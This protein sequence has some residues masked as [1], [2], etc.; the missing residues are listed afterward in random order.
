MNARYFTLPLQCQS[1]LS[2]LQIKALLPTLNLGL[3]LVKVFCM[4]S[5]DWSRDQQGTSKIMIAAVIMIVTVA[6]SY[7]YFLYP[8]NTSYFESYFIHERHFFRKK[9]RQMDMFFAQRF[10]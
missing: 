5:C 6:N 4:L 2:E 8:Y 1:E 3:S 10:I 9:A 7:V